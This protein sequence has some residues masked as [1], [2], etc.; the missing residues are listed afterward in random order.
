MKNEKKIPIRIS[1][2]WSKILKDNLG[3][4]VYCENDILNC[5]ISYNSLGKIAKESFSDGSEVL[6]KYDDKGRLIWFKNRNDEEVFYDL[7]DK[8]APIRIVYPDKSEELRE[9][10]ERL[11][12]TRQKFSDGSEIIFENFNEDGDAGIMKLRYSDGKEEVINLENDTPEIIDSI[13]REF[14]NSG[15]DLDKK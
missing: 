3:R 14:Y 9:Y 13:L 7:N 8:G 11:N 4:V 5:H 12:V 2:G 6:Y 10:D 15:K 1:R